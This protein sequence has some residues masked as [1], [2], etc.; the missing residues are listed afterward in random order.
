MAVRRNLLFPC[1]LI[2]FFKTMATSVLKALNS[3]GDRGVLI[4]DLQCL[5]RNV[6][7]YFALAKREKVTE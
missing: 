6:A 3:I 7:T 5:K 4:W 2:L 1:N